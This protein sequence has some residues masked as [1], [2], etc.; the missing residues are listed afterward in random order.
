MFLKHFRDP[1]VAGGLCRE[2]SAELALRGFVNERSAAF[3]AAS[4]ASMLHAR[5]HA[6]PLAPTRAPI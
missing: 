2:I 1:R 3:S 6:R 4:I 5:Q